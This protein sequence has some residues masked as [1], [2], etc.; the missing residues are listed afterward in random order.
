MVS[1]FTSS[2]ASP[3]SATATPVPPGTAPLTAIWKGM[4]ARVGSVGPL[5]ATISRRVT[6]HIIGPYGI[7]SRLEADSQGL[8]PTP[9]A[10][11]GWDRPAPD[12]ARGPPSDPPHPPRPPPR[13]EERRRAGVAASAS[14]G[15]RRRAGLAL[16]RTARSARRPR[17]RAGSRGGVRRAARLRS[18]HTGTVHDHVSHGPRRRGEPARVPGDRQGMVSEAH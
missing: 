15:D 8:G 18:Q 12:D 6:T 5:E 3:A 9:P 2:V 4:L 17:R 10:V 16:D 13:R 11:A 14:P 7:R 1:G